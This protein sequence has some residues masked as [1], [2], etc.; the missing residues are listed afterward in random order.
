MIVT[1]PLVVH[2]ATDVPHDLGDPLLSATILWWNAHTPW[3][4]ARWWDGFFFAPATGAL[5]FSDHRIGESVIAAPLIWAGAGPLT[6]YNVTLLAMFPLCAIAAHGLAYTLTRR[7]DAAVIAGLA[8]GFNPYR[9][10]HIEHLELLGAFGM[11]AALAALHLYL[12]DR[13]PRW[14]VAFALALLLQAL[15]CSYYFLFFLVMLGLWIAWFVRRG[16]R[17]LLVGVT[18][19]VAAVLACLSPLAFSYRAIHHHYGLTRGY[20]DIITLSADVTSLVTA[21][22]LVALWGWTSSWNG[23]ERQL[24]PGLTIALLAIAGG[25]AAWRARSTHAAISRTSLACVVVAS[26]CVLVAIGAALFGPWHVGV[27]DLALSVTTWFKPFSLGMAAL[28]AA[29]AASWTARTA[30]R[31]RSVLAFYL[32]AAAVLFLCSLGPKPA[33]LGRQFLYEPPYA[34]LMR[35]SVFGDSIRVPARFAMVGI[36]ALSTAG[37][38]AFARLTQRKQYAAVLAA[39]V[40]AES[41][42]RVPLVAPPPAWPPA[43]QTAGIASFV[44]LPLGDTFGDA[45]AMYRSMT[46]GVPTV[47]G[48]SGFEPT[49][50]D[51][52]RHGLDE[53]D[54]SVLDALAARGPLVVVSDRRAPYASEREAWLTGR[55]RTRAIASDAD[56]AWFV[57]EPQ[58]IE[59]P[60]CGAALPIAGV[61]QGHH[62]GMHEGHPAGAHGALDHG[63]MTTHGE[64][65][66]WT[67]PTAQHAGDA[68]V[69]DLGEVRRPCSIQLAL[70]DHVAAYPRALSVATSVDGAAWETTFAGQT[71]GRAVLAG[72]ARPRDARLEL[73]L[74]ENAAR[75]VRIRLEASHPTIPWIVTDVAVTASR[76]E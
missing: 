39:L 75:F 17:D 69:V 57:V 70:G 54:D 14:L 43:V 24:F 5:A 41:W 23:P 65:A 28:V 52:L 29:V 19:A 51:A 58:P 32:I 62:A 33:V 10:A 3:L 37:A 76:P 45:A 74:C 73:P 42:S 34:W 38:L 6:A 47:N 61:H 68:L 59:T 7:H 12:H 16:D 55:A 71:A 11:P 9:F 18:I 72:I 56:R 44:E 40:I 2:V 13:R 22:P 20:N 66:A 27:G 49:Y 30:Y 46:S 8:Y 35:A 63:G 4:S 1:F 21:S 25:I 36:L 26:I 50:Y 15:L 53:R 67:A 64:H 48:Y 60:T 31:R